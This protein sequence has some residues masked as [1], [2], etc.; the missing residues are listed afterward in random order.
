MKA[1]IVNFLIVA[2]LVS[3]GELSFG[4]SNVL[5][6]DDPIVEYNPNNPP[7]K[8]A[9]GVLAKWVRTKRL[10][11]NTDSFKAYHYKGVSFRL[12]FPANFDR[13]GNTK[14]P[15]IIMFHG[16][17]EKGVIY[18]NEF[19]LL[20][21]GQVHMNAVNNGTLNAFLLYP[22]NT[23]GFWGDSHF[24]TINDLVNNYLSDVHVDL[25]RVVVTGLSAGGSGTWNLI[26]NYPN[27]ISAAIPMSASSLGFIEEIPKFKHIPMWVSQGGLDKA[28]HPNT[29]EQV[30]NAMIAEGMNVKYTLYPNLGHG[31]WNTHYNEP[32]YFPF[33]KRANK[34]NPLVYF[35]KSEFCP[36]ETINARLGLT[37]GFDGYEW[38]RNG[39]II[40]GATSNE[41]VVTQFGTYD[42]RIRRGNNWS[43]WSVL[44]VEIKIK[45]PTITPPIALSGLVSKV[46]PSPDNAQGVSLEL[47]EGYVEYKWRKVGSSNILGTNR[48]YSATSAG[49]YEASVTELYGCSSNWSPA[50]RVIDANGTGGP[51]PASRL[52]VA[53]ISKTALKLDWDQDPNAVNNETGFEIYRSTQ[54][55]GEYRLIALTVADVNTY[56]DI[57][58]NQNATY[59]YIIRAVNDMGASQISNQ[60]YATTQADEIPP[61]SPSNL[62]VISTTSN[63]VTFTWD[64]SKDDVGVE[65]YEVFNGSF[66]S[67]ITEG[68]LTSATVYN[69][70]ENQVYNF[71]VKAKDR[72]GNYSSP[73]NQVTAAAVQT[74][75]QYKY[76]EGTWTLLPNFNNLTPKTTGITNNVHLNLRER[77]TNF[78]FYWE[79]FINIPVA[80]GYTF[81]TRSDDGS[82]LY[83]GNYNEA[84]LVVNNDGAHGMQYRE[85]RYT[86]PA[87]GAYKIIVTYFQ[88]GGGYG[89][90]LY[91]KNTAHGVGSTRQLIPDNVFKNQF[92][93]PGQAP[94][95]PS[96]LI[97]NTVSYDLIDLSWTDN[98]LDETGFQVLRSTNTA[99][100][101]TSVATLS[102]N[103]TS[104]SDVGLL[105]STTYFYKVQAIGKFGEAIGEDFSKGLSYKYYE[106]NSTYT[107]LAQM[108]STTPKKSGN[109]INFNITDRERS[110]RFGFVWQGKIFI[111]TS[112]NYTFFCRSISGSNLYID[113]SLVVSNDYTS[114]TTE[115]NGVINLSA[116]VHTIKVAYRQ[117]TATNLFLEVRYQGP[118]I[119][120]QFIPSSALRDIDINATTLPLPPPPQKPSNFIV[121]SI[122]SNKAELNWINSEGSDIEIWR[123]SPSNLNFIKIDILKNSAVG[124]QTYFDEDLFS[125]VNYYY[126]IVASG[127]GGKVSSDEV[128]TRT[129]NNLPSLVEIGDIS[130]RFNTILEIPIYSED[131]D[132]EPLAF[133]VQNLPGFAILEDYGDGSGR[134]LLTPSETDQALYE[135]VI[136]SV[137][138]TNGG[139]TATS[140]SILVNSN[141][142]PSFAPFD[143]LIVAEGE[144]V[145]LT[146]IASDNDGVET[147]QWNALGLPSF[148][149]FTSNDDGS[150]T[151]VATPSFIDH[152]NYPVELSI[153]D[154]Q[155]AS[156]S[157]SLL[158]KIIDRDP[159]I[160]VNVNIS[161]NV[162]GPQPWNNVRQAN[163]TNLIK[164][165]GE[166]SNI[167]LQFQ[168]SW[169]KTWYEGAT[170]GNNSGVYPDN[171]LRDYYY[172]GIFGGPNQ[173]NAVVNGL[174]PHRKY[175]LTFMASSNYSGASNNGTTLFTAFG[176]TVGVDVQNNTMNTASITNIIP[177]SNGTINFT[178]SKGNNS[179]AGYLNALV[180]R[181]VDGRNEVP[182]AARDLKAV[183]DKNSK[184][185]LTWVDAP[186]NESGYNIYRSENEY[187]QFIKLNE[188][189][190]IANSTSF[191]DESVADYT[192]YYYKVISFNNIGDSESSNV[193]SIAI[194]NTPPKLNVIGN[195][196]VFSGQSSSI[197]LS[198]S[199][200]PNNDLEIEIY[201]LPSFAR[202]SRLNDTEG[203][204]SITPSESDIGDYPVLVSVTDG[205]GGIISKE[206]LLQV[207]EEVLYSVAIN[208]SNKLSAPAP[209]NNTLKSPINGDKFINLVNNLGNTTPIALTLENS[210]GTY[211]AGAIT[212]DN[213][214]I[215]PDNVLK[216]YYY[217]GAFGSPNEV[218]IK[219][220][221]LDN[222]KKYRFS[223]IGSSIFSGNGVSDNGYTNYTIGSNTV[224]LYVQNNTD[225][226]VKIDNVT[227][228]VNG[229]VKV[230]MTKGLGA[231]VGYINGMII[232]VMEG[233]QSIFNP[234]NLK[235][236]GLSGSKISLTWSDN[237]SNELGFEIYR[238]AKNEE[239][240]F[241]LIYTTG[242]EVNSF[243]DSGL[244]PGNVYYYKVR[245]IL[246]NSISPFTNTAAGGTTYFAIYI[247]MNGEAIYDAPIPWNN[248]SRMPLDGDTFVGYKNQAGQETGIRLFFE[249][250]MTGSNDWGPSTGNNSG[251]Y[252]D[253]VLK[254][255]FWMNAYEEPA[256]IVVK[257][258]DQAIT[259]NISFFGAI[260]TTYVVNT[261]FII[262]NNKVT[263]SQTNNLDRVS[264]IYGLRP[265]E[266]NEI[267]IT[268]TENP[269]SRWAI[270]NAMVIEG[271]PSG[272]AENKNSRKL[273]NA[274]FY[275]DGARVVRYGESNP[276]ISSYPNPFSDV[277]NVEILDSSLGSMHITLIDLMGR[278]VFDEMVRSEAID[279][280][281]IFNINDIGLKSGLY[282]L[283][284]V[285]PDGKTEITRVVKN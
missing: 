195:W 79:G 137:S 63:S 41:I 127:P 70:V 168:T 143:D 157:S 119:S 169:W 109:S 170:T 65:N 87:P 34:T 39:I 131:E 263:N 150:A 26:I 110:T 223:F 206:F 125:N 164:T 278:V 244:S 10:G 74:G 37:A 2:T 44:P 202:Y 211:N 153:T 103:S 58:L 96:N 91:W 144:S 8:P 249:N 276:K 149:T 200:P 280:N 55:F 75:L 3:F 124:L 220:D 225:R 6:P 272:L 196:V 214:G 82:K 42:V 147:L 283:R 133:A 233:S 178:M 161:H 232:E 199:D 235:A 176:Q 93:M 27:L 72:A 188:N 68:P 253:K 230:N 17:G 179:P 100:P 238:S 61:T 248:M 5:N 173:V 97:A 175:E 210:F 191:V 166:V 187:G 264:T 198:A 62:R 104:F 46:F 146:I 51:N 45:D 256:R 49:D 4:Q 77:N 23:N 285:L 36:G 129:L 126:K 174:D 18:D 281:L 270:F 71:T 245:A 241:N 274:E 205:F 228:N 1:L 217:F 183:I 139:N 22:Q 25:N 172:F 12:K 98:S 266:K 102:K 76:Y 156:I 14:Y 171:V 201:G 122:S 115:R 31:V 192:T 54:D 155:G 152:G 106:S 73:S 186:F 251:I 181:T 227:A 142:I 237:S 265:D 268:I 159:N 11:W 88:G 209:W 95:A 101:F 52:S 275:V 267:G 135:N 224:S 185:L 84:N 260:S 112:G 243:I 107:S 57:D 203:I 7:Q 15:L 213:S 204:I 105:G 121:N 254:S 219:V 78:A 81:E 269:G 218:S 262:G 282:L 50:F 154:N 9:W 19:S 21:G 165:N 117:G 271:Y 13:S 190:L 284:I 189:P 132:N 226:M 83:I 194:P 250:S 99:G 177:E 94:M 215:A 136:L 89:M 20:H 16:R 160:Q 247:N 184:V 120:K 40:P 231:A 123:S 47:P 59:Y 80:G 277:L 180:I 229:E 138:D 134:I 130:M 66:K 239:G 145:S 33:I 111:P 43:N 240:D 148:V 167:G 108:E 64:E 38:R 279:Q 222:S 236:V 197:T 234:S 208:F 163:T 67:A 182:A 56:V 140:F 48:S 162:N 242:A 69:L 273:T 221:G 252:P 151:I 246:P 141:H 30:I 114:S 258:L 86:F 28:P 216:E 116:G 212:G 29:T 85:G 259:Y 53:A 24:A 35:G 255:F 118:G 60:A 193:Y 207:S 92:I 257:G 90:E 128:A 113:G 261:D 158:I 32:D